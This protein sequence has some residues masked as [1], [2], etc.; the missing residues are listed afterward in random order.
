M[1]EV[2]RIR[3]R[4]AFEELRRRGHRGGAGPVTV[5]W[6]PASGSRC[7]AFAVGRAVGSA[8]VRNRLRRRLR[9]AVED[10]A[11]ELACG[12]YMIGASPGAVNLTFGEL[13]A[14]VSRAVADVRGRTGG[15]GP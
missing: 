9:A 14:N 3:G 4:R 13:R 5:V 7:V 1:R 6:L 11:P 2:D 15:V 10:L 8:V 12:A